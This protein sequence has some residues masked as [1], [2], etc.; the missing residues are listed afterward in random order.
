MRIRH[1][2]GQGIALPLQRAAT[3]LHR[4]LITILLGML[5]LLPVCANAKDTDIKFSQLEDIKRQHDMFK[6][7]KLSKQNE[8]QWDEENPTK[9]FSNIL[10]ICKAITTSPD[11]TYEEYQVLQEL[12]RHALEKR[13]AKTAVE[14]HL[15][16]ENQARVTESL[17]NIDGFVKRADPETWQKIR[18]Q[19]ATMILAFLKSINELI[20]PNFKPKEVSINVA[21]ASDSGPIM[22]GMNP[23][24]IA[25]PS[26]RKIYEDSIRLNRER[27]QVNK[28]Q[29]YLN[30][31]LERYTPKVETYLINAYSMPPASFSELDSLLKVDG[32]DEVTRARILAAV[33][34]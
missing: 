2:H 28:E 5:C 15:V 25:N 16:I 11:I 34:K 10:A 8:E 4:H 33:A 26:K 32:I 6:F 1:I 17:M 22:A 27:I 7:L 18:S 23:D 13:A 24:A 3:V 19:N 29:F 20:I 31:L 30:R 12:N 9:Y 21:P 14:R